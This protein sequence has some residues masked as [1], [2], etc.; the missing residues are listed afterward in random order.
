MASKTRA[1]GSP[2]VAVSL[3][4][5]RTHASVTDRLPDR[6]A[7]H[8]ISSPRLWLALISGVGNFMDCN[9]SRQLLI[10]EELWGFEWDES[11]SSPSSYQPK[12]EAVFMEQTDGWTDG[13][14]AGDDIQSKI[15]AEVGDY[16][17]ESTIKTSRRYSGLC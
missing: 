16:F 8:L 17:K 10:Y 5:P 1:K 7:P 15:N 12:E 9:S 13:D 14:A 3:T 4:D 11:F 6:L 2:S